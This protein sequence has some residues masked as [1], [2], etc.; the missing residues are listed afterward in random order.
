MTFRIKFYVFWL[1]YTVL[2]VA[3]IY[4]SFILMINLQ[5]FQIVIFPCSSGCTFTCCCACFKQ[6]HLH[7]VHSLKVTLRN[8]KIQIMLS[9]VMK[10][11]TDSRR[12]G[13]YCYRIFS[14]SVCLRELTNVP[15]IMK[16]SRF[17]K[18]DVRRNTENFRRAFLI[19]TL[20]VI[21]FFLMW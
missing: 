10:D 9:G 17:T 15:T 7:L 18:L 16:P 5:L 20:P 2:L 8:L 3:N 21:E 13:A 19:K 11:R 4:V 6:F 12:K 1:Y 14:T